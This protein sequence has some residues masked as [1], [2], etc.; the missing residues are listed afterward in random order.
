MKR[1][2]EGGLSVGPAWLLGFGVIAWGLAW[3]PLEVTSE[4]SP[5]VM[6]ASLRMIPSALT[7]LAGYLLI[8]GT[9]PRGRVLVGAIV[10]GLLV[11][12]FFQWALMASVARVGA[13]NSAVV[14]NTPP[15]MVAI[16]GWLVLRERVSRLAIAGLA[17]GFGGVVLM[18]ATQLGGTQGTGRLLSGVGLGLAAALAWAVA[19]LI[20][21]ALT[22]NN[23][24]VDIV[25][26][27]VV[28]YTAGALVLVPIAFATVGT[29]S[30]DWSSP[31]LWAP[32]AWV[33]PV[34]AV[35]VLFFFTVL[36]HMEAA[37]ASSVLFL[38]PAIAV[39]VE[40]AR[41]NA[42]GAL[43]LSGMFV[44]VIGVALVTTPSNLPSRSPLLP[45]ALR[46]R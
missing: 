1:L 13:G 16:L 29:S 3:W 25:G 44:A 32:M 45:S 42:P 31:E 46:S 8:R 21:R 15:L 14:T 34:T 2:R 22:R 30:T 38:V 28:Q 7:L 33:G 20:M 41:G 18:V 9:L 4:H 5:P 26:V 35:A 37:R 10:T 27:S 6:L 19:T 40:I 39:L 43:T 17:T 12:A 11:F 23:P 24:K 36:K